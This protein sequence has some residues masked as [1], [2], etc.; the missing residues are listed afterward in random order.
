MMPGMM[1]TDVIAVSHT[2]QELTEGI[3]IIF[4][5]PLHRK[6][7]NGSHLR[8]ALKH[9]VDLAAWLLNAIS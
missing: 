8:L 4:M 9:V 1:Q 7:L 5:V 3:K 6:L 2:H